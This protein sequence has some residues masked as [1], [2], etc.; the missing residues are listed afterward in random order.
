MTGVQTCALPICFPVTIGQLVFFFGCDGI[1]DLLPQR[2]FPGCFRSFL[3]LLLAGC[4]NGL[5]KVKHLAKLSP[6]RI[7]RSLYKTFFL[8]G[9]KLRVNADCHVIDAKSIPRGEGHFPELLYSQV[10]FSR[11]KAEFAARCDVKEV[12]FRHGDR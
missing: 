2:G 9:F 10:A 3:I 7:R 4:N 11:G 1:H 8:K 5:D 12:D 6:A